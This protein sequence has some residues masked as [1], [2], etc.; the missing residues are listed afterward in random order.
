[1]VSRCRAA[2]GRSTIYRDAQG[3]WHGQVS[4]GPTD[5]GKPV[6]RHVRGRS[7]SEVT[8]KVELLAAERTRSAG[9][10]VSGQQVTAGQW[11]DEW[12]VIIQRTRKPKT[13]DTYTSLVR[14]H[15]GPLRRIPIPRL[16]VRD[17]DDLLHRAAQRSPQSAVLLHQMPWG[18]SG[19]TSTS[20][21]VNCTSA[22]S[23][24]GSVGTTA[25]EPLSPTIH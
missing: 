9:R 3:T 6:R 13:H 2:N 22:A 20:T 1:M 23:C 5:N 14:V 4:M 8:A 12:L 24:S 17:I 15:C 10:P 7:R 18:C 16:T 21:A 11:L 19:E 25:V